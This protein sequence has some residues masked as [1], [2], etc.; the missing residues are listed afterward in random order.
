MSKRDFERIAQALR[1]AMPPVETGAVLQHAQWVHDVH[2]MADVCAHSSARFIRARFLTAC[3]IPTDE[4]WE[5]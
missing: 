4:R 1:E 2:A 5:R 3:G